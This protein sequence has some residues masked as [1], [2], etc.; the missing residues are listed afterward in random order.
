MFYVR[1]HFAVAQPNR[2]CNIYGSPAASSTTLQTTFYTG[3]ALDSILPLP[4][5]DDKASREQMLAVLEV[6]G[7]PEVTLLRLV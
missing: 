3:P 6:P 2:Q 4:S 1:L 5:S 7:L